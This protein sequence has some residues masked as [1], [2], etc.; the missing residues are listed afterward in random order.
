MY[1]YY[2]QPYYQQ[3]IYNQPQQPVNKKNQLSLVNENGKII[4]K[5]IL[6]C[7]K[8]MK[9]TNI[10]CT[11]YHHPKADLDIMRSHHDDQK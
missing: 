11:D 4:C 10:N 1:H 9:C 2:M 5:K 8:G 7:I 3:Q 6:T